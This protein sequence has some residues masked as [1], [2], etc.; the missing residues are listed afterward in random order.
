[1]NQEATRGYELESTPGYRLLAACRRR[2]AALRSSGPEK[3]ARWWEEGE[4]HATR[5]S[6]LPLASRTTA[7]AEAPPTVLVRIPAFTDN[8]PAGDGEAQL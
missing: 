7:V 8:G 2:W 3:A 5:A 4:S 6:T 1:M